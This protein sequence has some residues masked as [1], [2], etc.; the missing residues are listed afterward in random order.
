MRK[1]RETYRLLVSGT[2][3]KLVNVCVFEWRSDVKLW[4]TPR[5]WGC[6]GRSVVMQ[7]GIVGLR[8]LYIRKEPNWWHCVG[9]V[10]ARRQQSGGGRFQDQQPHLIKALF[11]NWV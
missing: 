5:C 11:A 6:V 8:C 10:R 9:R 1:R 7:R 2:E 4:N 3:G